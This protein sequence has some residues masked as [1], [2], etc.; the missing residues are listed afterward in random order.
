MRRLLGTGAAALGALGVLVCAAAL[1]GGWWAAV[2]TTDRTTRAASR[3]NHGLS[4]ADARL[5]RVEARL[6]AVRAGLAD[7]RGEAEKLA[8]ENPELPR[9]RAAI[10]RLLD[11]LLP[12]IDR[13]AAL[14][15]SLR[16]VAVG[17]RA[18]EDVVVQLGGE[19]EHPSRARTAADTI[20]RAGEVLNIPQARIDAVKSAAAVRLTRE[21]IELVREAVAGSERLAEG[22]AD[23]RREI[24]GAQERIERRRVQIVFWVH[25]AAVAHTLVWVWIGL[26]QV[27]LVGWGRRIAR[28]VPTIASSPVRPA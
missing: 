27:C 3:L 20:D 8:A 21:L 6:T 22:L 26:G 11:R 1:G 5:E 23:A 4:E 2:R 19:F 10:E 7:A 9:V 18:A 16:A 17:L 13:A 14:A 28:R 15:D 24:T 25:V 12:T